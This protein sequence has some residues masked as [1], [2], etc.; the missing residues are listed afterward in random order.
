MSLTLDA[1]PESLAAL[2]R[3][4]ARFDGAGEIS[5]SFRAKVRLAA[6][7]K[8]PGRLLLAIQ[9]RELRPSSKA[10]ST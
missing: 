5:A 7:E 6:D 3:E 2:G 10:G 9:I 4:L 8:V 1:A